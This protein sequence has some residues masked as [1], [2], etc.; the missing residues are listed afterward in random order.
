MFLLY[1]VS[2]TSTS[3]NT[4]DVRLY[5]YHYQ[6]RYPGGECVSHYRYSGRVWE[7]G[8]DLERASCMGEAGARGA[9]VISD[10]CVHTLWEGAAAG[11][12]DARRP[13]AS[14]CQLGNAA[15]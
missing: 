9:A 11:G 7:A 1:E 6:Y 3:R 8:S 4:H 14:W 2:G 5:H 10:L 15:I 13:S 12:G